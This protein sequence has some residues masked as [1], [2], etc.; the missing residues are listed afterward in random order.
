MKGS[1]SP[2]CRLKGCEFSASY[3]LNHI[4]SMFKQNNIV[5][6]L[7]TVLQVVS[8]AFDRIFV[9]NLSNC[10]I[11]ARHGLHNSKAWLTLMTITYGTNKWYSLFLHLTSSSFPF[12]IFGVGRLA[13]L[14]L[15]LT[16][17]GINF[18]NI[19]AIGSLITESIA[20]KQL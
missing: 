4:C 6:H 17:Y 10:C 18:L 2:N 14:L 11:T 3:K 9:F 8:C 19:I 15:L 7:S 1:S 20:H 5:L 12:E 16:K 13:S